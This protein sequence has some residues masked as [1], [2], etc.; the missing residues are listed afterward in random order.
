MQIAVEILGKTHEV[1]MAISHPLTFLPL[2]LFRK[3]IFN[4]L[5]KM[6]LL[7]AET[8]TKRGR[9]FQKRKDPI[10][11]YECRRKLIRSGA[12]TLSEKW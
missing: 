6:G 12:I 10:F 4:W 2:Y 9:W 3:S 8:N 7:Y 5:E 1:T 11:G